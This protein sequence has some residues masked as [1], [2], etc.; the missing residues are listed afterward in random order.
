MLFWNHFVRMSFCLCVC[1]ISSELLNHFFF[2]KLGMIVYYY[3]AM[4][5][6]EKLVHYLQYQGHSKGLNKQNMTTSTMSSKLL[7]HLLPNLV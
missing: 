3:E 2:T 1:S 4:C 6:A 7:F 5:H